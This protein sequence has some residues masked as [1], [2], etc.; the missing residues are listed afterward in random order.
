MPAAAGVQSRSGRAGFGWKNS[1][2]VCPVSAGEEDSTENYLKAFKAASK[3][4]TYTSTQETSIAFQYN[5]SFHSTQK[6]I[7]S[8]D[9]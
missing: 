4:L 8:A 2:H 3:L 6:L 9:L 7:L 5:I 1:W